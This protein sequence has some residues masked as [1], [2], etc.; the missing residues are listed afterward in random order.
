VIG[1]TAALL[2]ALSL[3]I[4]CT[5]AHAQAAAAQLSGGDRSTEA[6][7]AALERR[8]RDN[9]GALSEAELKLVH[10][11]PRR[12]LLWV[13]PTNDINSPAN[14]P[15]HA[16]EWHPGRT[17]RAAL[18]RWLAA[19]P[20]ARPYV[21][22]SGVG[23]GGAKIDGALDLSYLTLAS[24]VTILSSAIPDGVDFSF[25]RIPGLDLSRSTTGPIV[26]DRAVI[27]GDLILTA[28]NFGPTSLFRTEIDGSLDCSG[29]AFVRGD[30]PL[31]LVEA[32]IKGDASF[33]AGFTTSGVVDLRLAEVE[34]GL[35]F[36]HARFVGAGDN[37][38]NAER[39]KIDGTLYWVDI[40][41][42]PRTELDLAN[43][44]AAALWDDA[45]SWPAPG[46]LFLEGFAYGDLSGGPADA[47]SRLKWL[48][49]QPP[50]YRPQPYGQLARVLRERGSDIGAVSVLIA[51]E[52]ARRRQRELGVGERLW[53]LLLDA[54]IGYGYRPIRALW[55]IFGFVALGAMLF[56]FGYHERAITPTEPAAYQCFVRDGE[57]PPH[58]PPFNAVIYSLENFLP[59]VDLHQG[60]YWRPNPRHGSGGRMRMLSGTVLRWY[61]WLHILA[62]W[63]ITPLF[64]AGLS[65]LVRPD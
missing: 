56:R 45:A 31:S 22:P 23:V 52:D 29:A 2:A 36:N 43:A 7:G 3:G 32:T 55:W 33:H 58:Y 26:G 19:D 12:A 40:T 15:A 41:R 20:A 62:G 21:H 49:L 35:S 25:A 60:L 34:R 27:G 13:G 64:A 16:A 42:T 54:T 38:L 11:A 37:G 44:R 9:F 46:R 8:A 5:F 1:V 18:I 59:V 65:G 24:P 51:K 63:V 61:L 53:G 14:D 48:A 4:R 47:P 30:D 17:I 10:A 6:A 57:P 50:G 28:G 39:A